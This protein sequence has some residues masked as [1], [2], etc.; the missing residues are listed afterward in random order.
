MEVP[1]GEPG[2]ARRGRSEPVGNRG[3]REPDRPAVLRPV[4]EDQRGQVSGRGLRLLRG[5]SQS[6]V[7]RGRVQEFGEEGS[8]SPVQGIEILRQV[9]A[10]FVD[11]EP[12][13]DG[14]A[15]RRA[16]QSSC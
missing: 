7:L 3:D 13:R 16:V 12:D 4:H 15:S 2:Q 6:E 14:S 11:F 10:R 8:R 9:F 1:A 5:H